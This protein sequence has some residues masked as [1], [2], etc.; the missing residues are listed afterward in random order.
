MHG[1]KR[2]RNVSMLEW[3]PAGE[4]EHAAQPSAEQWEAYH[5]LCDQNVTNFSA[6]EEAHPVNFFEQRDVCGHCGTERFV[7]MQQ[8]MC[9]QHG[10]LVLEERVLPPALASL[11]TSAPGLSKQS[12][13]A[14]DLYRFAQMALPKGTHRMPDSYQH[15]KVTGIP[16]AILPNLNERT[17]TRAFLDD[18]YERNVAR[19]QFPAGVQPSDA[20]IETIHTVLGSENV[21]V[22]R[23]INWAEASTHTARLVLKWPGATHAVRAF[24]V[25]PASAVKHPR[26]VF[27]TRKDEDERCY[28]KTSSPEY[29]PLMWPLAFPYGKPAFVRTDDCGE[30]ALLD[31]YA[32]NLQQATLALMLQPERH[33]NGDFIYVPTASPYGARQPVVRRFSRLELMGR[34]G[35]EVLVD[36]WLSVLDDRLRFISSDWMQRRLLGFDGG[37]NGPETEEDVAAERRGNY[38]PAS[39][40]GT[41]RHMRQNCSNA[42]ATLRQLNA[43]YMMFITATTDKVDH[44][45]IQSRLAHVDAS[46]PRKPAQD[47]FDR[48]ALH[49][50]VF[51]AKAEALLARLRTGTIFRNLGR[52]TVETVDGLRVY[53]YPMTTAGGGFLIAAVEDQVGCCIRIQA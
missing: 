52:P 10:K 27:F 35:D 50:E 21:L 16:F 42:M 19:D 4:Q 51:N 17:S 13:V 45:E 43:Q 24:T 26:T 9:C 22:R 28:V 33:A 8:G 41:P 14:N 18:P 30:L 37:A 23:L 32:S 15:L 11:I 38:L 46:N 29:A 5:K 49:A 12:R 1:G 44:P 34:L 20:A 7:T 6:T 47:V 25:D 53:K 39:E 40:I 2:I 36:R 3:A 31:E 48:A